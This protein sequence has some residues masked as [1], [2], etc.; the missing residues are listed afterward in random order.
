[1]FAL[2][3]FLHD[4]FWLLNEIYTRVSRTLR[5]KKSRFIVILVLTFS[6]L[7]VMKNLKIRIFQAV[8]CFL[9]TFSIKY[10]IKGAESPGKDGP[11]KLQKILI[12]RN[13]KNCCQNMLRLLSKIEI[14]PKSCAF[15]GCCKGMGHVY[16]LISLYWW[17]KKNNL[18]HDLIF[19]I[20]LL[21]NWWSQPEEDLLSPN[22]SR[23]YMG[24]WFCAK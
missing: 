4:P 3:A 6:F 13:I 20:R 23:G 14:P 1:M 15:W 16:E 5:I 24:D 9:F 8:L 17:P 21:T 19:L 18:P 7:N 22:L 12:A 2:L 10:I 11:K